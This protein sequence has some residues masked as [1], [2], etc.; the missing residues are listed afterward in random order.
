MKQVALRAALKVKREFIHAMGYQPGQSISLDRHEKPSLV[1]HDVLTTY[2]KALVSEIYDPRSQLMRG[3]YFN[4]RKVYLLKDI[5][6]EPRLGLV[7]SRDGYLVEESTNWP[8]YQFYN[9]FPWT[10][11]KTIPKSVLPTA[12]FL[13]SSA[14]GHWL[15]EDLPLAIFALR[16]YP[17]APVLVA[18]NPPKFVMDFLKIINRDVIYLDGPMQIDSLILV[19]KNQDSG[20]PHP[21][22]LET[23]NL[24][25]PFRSAKAETPA[26]KK[27]YASR[28]G[29]KRS[30]KNEYEIEMLFQEYGFDVFQLEQLD[31]LEEIK[32]L[33]T[34]SVI[35]GVHGSALSNV[36]WMPVG[37]KMFDI[38]NDNYWTEAGHRLAF[39]QECQYH[40]HRYLGAVDS[41]ISI[42]QLQKQLA[43]IYT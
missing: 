25:E 22:D 34:T 35:A 9:S 14:F 8:I 13:P 30:P 40:Y 26:T 17:Q 4:E 5:V 33:S 2:S 3:H 20:W 10:P 43:E 36:I 38:V 1:S 19:Q 32:L 41:P 11:K 15:M 6:L 27:V 23:L 42:I 16:F 12:I 37:G 39:L 24:F 28:R 29:A 31:L 18:S 7:Y 21:K